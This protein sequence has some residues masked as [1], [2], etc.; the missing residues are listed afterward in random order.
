MENLNILKIIKS[1]NEIM[2][3][4]QIVKASGKIILK[5]TYNG[6]AQLN[7][8]LWVVNEITLKAS[9]CGPIDSAI[10]LIKRGLVSTNL[11]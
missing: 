7:P 1:L 5:N 2:L 9:R 10:R 6:Q 11:S 4:Q 3:A 8:S